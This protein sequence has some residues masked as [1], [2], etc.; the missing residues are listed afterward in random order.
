MNDMFM[1]KLRTQPI[2]GIIH[3]IMIYNEANLTD[4]EDQWLLKEIKKV[5][6]NRPNPNEIVIVKK[7][8]IQFE[9]ERPRD[10][11]L[12]IK[13][14]TSFQLIMQNHKSEDPF[15]DMVLCRHGQNKI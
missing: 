1:E 3:E 13:K 12:E 7:G 4:D 11:R 14:Y 15:K 2:K 8:G 10:F 9:I 6:E 5:K